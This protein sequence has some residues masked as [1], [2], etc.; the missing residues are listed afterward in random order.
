VRLLLVALLVATSAARAADTL[1]VFGHHWTVP[2]REDW[3]VEQADGSTV[4]HLVTGREPP[5]GPRRPMQFAVA[6]TPAFHSVAVEAQ[7]KPLR[8]SLMIVFAYR[9][10]AHF[11]YAHLSTDTGAK[12]PHHNGIFHVYGGERVRIS[13]EA[14]PAAFSGLNRWYQVRLTFD[15]T[16][17]RVSVR[18]DGERI[19]ALDAV[20]LS[21]GSG[22]V[23]VGSFDETGDFRNV[24]IT[25]Q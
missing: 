7:V 25:G 16:S 4:L 1:E 3:N 8:R 6:E 20:D 15:G 21:L 19:P 9:D 5:P 14:G 23:G 13:S 10:A 17:G 22:R 11:D 18:V 12:E 24:R 2:N